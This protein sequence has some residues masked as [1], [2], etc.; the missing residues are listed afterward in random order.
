MAHF[1]ELNADNKVLR[2]IVVSNNELLDSNGVEQEELGK[3]FCNKLL[4]GNWIQCSYNGSFRTRMPSK[5]YTYDVEKDAFIPP[6]QYD[7]FIFNEEL[8]LW[9]APV[10]YP[11]DGNQYIWNEEIKNWEQV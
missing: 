2:V 8:L 4:G 3:A 11:D 5:N 10:S 7:S 1:A 9:M 6:K